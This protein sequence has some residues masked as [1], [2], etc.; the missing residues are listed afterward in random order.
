M[1]IFGVRMYTLSVV[2]GVPICKHGR[3]V[4]CTSAGSTRGVPIWYTWRTPRKIII[5]LLGLGSFDGWAM[6]C[7]VICGKGKMVFYPLEGSDMDWTLDFG[8]CLNY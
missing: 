5:G 4:L 3:V 2:H 8:N 1:S 7:W 6:R